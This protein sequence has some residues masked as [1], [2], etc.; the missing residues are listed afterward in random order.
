MLWNLATVTEAYQKDKI[1]EKIAV[2]NS[3]QIV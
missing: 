3:N 2:L 1:A